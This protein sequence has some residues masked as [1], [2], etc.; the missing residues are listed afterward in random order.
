MSLEDLT[1]GQLLAYAQEME[2]NVSVLHSIAS[3]AETRTAFQRILKK[4]NPNTPIPELDAVDRA[5]ATIIK[6][7]T[8]KVESLER[9]LQERDILAR[10]EKQRAA[11]QEKYHLSDEDMLAVQA[12]MVDKDHPIPSYDAAARVHVASRQSA[13][14]TP[15][16]YAP[17]VYDMPA[18]ETWAAGIGNPA[19]LNRIG[20]TKAFEAWNDLQSGKVPGLGAARG[21]MR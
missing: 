12:L 6:P 15:A 9:T 18:K 4:L 8:D 10:L 2:Q 11:V 5:N 14:S 17:P 20:L 16:S 3:N 7:L 19:M 21:A 1:P 13:P